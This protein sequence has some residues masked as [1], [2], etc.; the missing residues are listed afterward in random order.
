MRCSQRGRKI[1]K[2]RE[3][4]RP[5]AYI[6][7]GG[8][9][10]IGWGFTAYEDGT[11]VSLSDHPITLERGEQLL[12]WYLDSIEQAIA[13]LVRQPLNQNQFDALC[14]FV[15][16]VGVTQF[17]Q[18]TLL[19]RINVNPFHTDIPRQFMR[20]VYDNGEVVPGLM[21]RRSVE[22]RLYHEPVQ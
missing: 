22:L 15:Y 5:S 8:K 6:D 1:L 20:W 14:I 13:G 19:K 16:N 3:G 7:S 9:P 12:S 18:S 17:A 11:P 4:W 21:K 2:V 10:T